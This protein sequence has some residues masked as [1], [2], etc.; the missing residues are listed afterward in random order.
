MDAYWQRALRQRSKR[1]QLFL[2]AGLTLIA[3]G[4]AALALLVAPGER[5]ANELP[6]ELA[7]EPNAYL[8]DG[9][10]TQFRDDGSLHY[11]LAAEEIRYFKHADGDFT[12]LLA[13]VLELPDAHSQPWLLTAE[14]GV[15]RSVPAAASTE[16]EAEAAAD[17]REEAII[18]RGNVTL[19]QQRGDHRFT[20]VY[21]DALVVYPARRFAQTG[22]DV[23]AGT[24]ASDEA[25]TEASTKASTK[26]GAMIV[27]EASRANVASLEADL[28]SG[29]IKLLSSGSQ[30]VSIVVEP[31]QLNS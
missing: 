19:R 4:F 17:Q 21:A 1:P 15:A 20:A 16:T 8:R 5:P 18:L 23:G 25:G 9:V 28:Q 12:S 30:R 6:A 2:W 3:G 11:R 24:E 26:E 10:I 27:T 14:R 31:S 22:A 7:D 29:S 13:P